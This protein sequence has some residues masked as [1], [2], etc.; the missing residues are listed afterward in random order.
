VK[1]NA[2]RDLRIAISARRTGRRWEFT[3]AD[4]G[5]GIAPEFADKIWGLFQTLERRDKIE[6]TG[7]GLSVVR[8][9]VEAH[10]GKAWVDSELGHGATFRFTWPADPDEAPHG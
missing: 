5:I 1:Y 10:G 9:I 4:D 7:I 3:I 2:S 8:K 6:S